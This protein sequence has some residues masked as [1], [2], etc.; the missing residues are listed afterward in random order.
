MV[1]CLRRPGG[2]LVFIETH[3]NYSVTPSQQLQQAVDGLFGEDTYYAKVDA[4]LPERQKRAW[5]RKA[6]NGDS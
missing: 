6:D 2:E 4:T 1:L 3:E 5:E